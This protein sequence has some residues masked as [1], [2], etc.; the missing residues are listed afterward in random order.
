V[1]SDKRLNGLAH[2]IVAHAVSGLSYLHPHIAETCRASGLPSLTLDLL[3]PSPLPADIRAEKPCVLATEALHRTFVTLLKKLGFT[4]SDVHSAT[5]T[6]R[7]SVAS[8]DGSI[9]PCAIDLT[10][11]RGH[12]YHHEV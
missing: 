7:G 1:P 8:P 2:D 6:F 5:L 4:V 9:V 10:T 3:S 12:H 11:T